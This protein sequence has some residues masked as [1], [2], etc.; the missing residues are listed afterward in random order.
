MLVF[1]SDLHFEDGSAG[2]H[3]INYRA[4]QGFTQDLRKL[5]K[6]AKEI[7]IILLGDIFDLN[8]SAKWFEPGM[9]KPW[10][11]KDPFAPEVGESADKIMDEIIAKNGNSLKVI[12]NWTDG[13]FKD[14][15]VD[16]IFIPGN[17]DRL[18]NCFPSLRRRIRTELNIPGEDAPFEHVYR[19]AECRVMAFHGHEFDPT[20]FSMDYKHGINFDDPSIYQSIPLGDVISAEFGAQLYY[21][22][23]ELQKTDPNVQDN[24][25]FQEFLQH[26]S[27]I[28]NVRPSYAVFDWIY[29]QL[30]HEGKYA[31]FFEKVIDTVIDNILSL[32]Y[33][34]AWL[35]KHKEF[36]IL[37]SVVE[38]AES[39]YNLFAHKKINLA[40]RFL[41]WY[42]ENL[43]GKT[44]S[45]D[46]LNETIREQVSSTL[47]PSL[48]DYDYFV[49]GHTHSYSL[50]PIRVM[51]NGKEKVYINSGT[52]RKNVLKCYKKGYHVVNQLTSLCFYSP[53][54]NSGDD[55]RQIYEIWNGT[56]KES[57]L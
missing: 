53:S 19:S 33:F 14:K 50:M 55:S 17:H 32:D 6:D 5:S 8:R 40:G 22:A 4:F 26:I 36:K 49:A 7:H 56:L 3:N 29:Y 34:K 13:A 30:Q 23:V 2:D 48:A 28:D 42:F 20:N 16:L 12:R 54:E 1:I 44:G 37:D 43:Y 45:P 46:H 38:G 18:V 52:W 31:E 39:L 51:N 15:N 57:S 21:Q 47:I 25:E 27:D 24:A 10:C 9:V 41:E 11:R 35:D